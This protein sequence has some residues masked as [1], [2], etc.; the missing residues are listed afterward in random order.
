MCKIPW[1]KTTCIEHGNGIPAACTVYC[2]YDTGESDRELPSSACPS[3]ETKRTCMSRVVS[4]R[5]T[6]ARVFQV[7]A[8]S[9][10]SPTWH[11][12]MFRG[13]W[14]KSENGVRLAIVLRMLPSLS[15]KWVVH[16]TDSIHEQSM[17]NNKQHNNKNNITTTN[18]TTTNN[19]T[20]TT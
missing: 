14:L 18:N 15:S 6:T 5:V 16:Y 2:P 12:Y 8:S 13:L 3:V 4:H 7:Q 9:V 20:K 17:N 1:D 19:I 10:T 11:W